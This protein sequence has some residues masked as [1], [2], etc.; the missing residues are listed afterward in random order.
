MT[1]TQRSRMSSVWPI[2][3]ALAVFGP[4]D[5]GCAQDWPAKQPIKVIVPL[6]AGSTADVVGRTVFQQVSKQINQA[7]VI[8]NRTGAGTTIGTT[9][10]AQSEPDGYTILVTTA[11]LPVIATTFGS[12]LSFK[13]AE[14]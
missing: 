7:I 1:R 6:T 14:D 13:V 2:L 4:L 12:K 11:S 10:V 9:A 5:R 8:E 3:A